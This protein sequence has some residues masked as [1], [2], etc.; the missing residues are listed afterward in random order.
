MALLLAV[1]AC[2]GYAHAENPVR[3]HLD[4]DGEWQ[5]KIDPLDAGEQQR[6]YLLQ[7]KFDQTI[8]V[9]GCWQAQGIGSPSGILRHDYSGN[10]WYRRVVRVPSDWG[11]RRITL[12]I[13][14]ALRVVTAFVNGQPAGRHDGMSAPFAFD[15]TAQVEPGADN[16]IALRVANPGAAPS[17]SP[18]RQP[19]TRPTGSLNA[20]GNWGG[21]FEPVELQAT[22]QVWLDRIRVRSE[23]E[24]KTIHFRV[25][26]RNVTPERFTGSLRV[27]VPGT[28][29]KGDVA[30]PPGQ[31]TET[32]LTL[33]MPGAQLWSPEHPSLYSAVISLFRGAE[34][35][36]RLEQRFG[37]SEVRTQGNV[38]LLNNKP[39]YLRGYGDDDVEILSGTPSSSRETYVK[40]LQLARAM[41]FNAV[42]FHSMTP[43]REFYEAADE[44]GILVMAELPVAYTQYLLPFK[45]FLRSELTEVLL[46]YDNHPS[47]L[48]LALGNEFNLTWLKDDAA[49]GEFLAT[50]ADFYKLAKSLDPDRLILS[51]DG[52]LMEPTDMVSKSGQVS[53]TH[54][55]VRHEFGG[56]YCSLPDVSLI[57]RFSGV[58]R[59]LWLE[60]KQNWIQENGLAAVYPT[61][62]KNSTILQYLGHKYEIEK[63]RARQDVTGYHYWL[64]VDF[65]GGTGEGDS[66]EEGWLNYFWEP[67]KP[68]Q[69]VRGLNSAVLMMIGA[70]VDDRTFWS[71]AGKQTG[72]LVSNYG[73]EDIEHGTLSWKLMDQDRAL[74]GSQVT[75]VGV[76]MGRV[77]HVADVHIGPIQAREAKKLSLVLELRSGSRTYSNDWDFWVFPRG[78]LMDRADRPVV[79]S[80]KWGGILRMY[81]FIKQ[82]S[83]LPPPDS[84]LLTSTLNATAKQ[85]LLAGGR[86]WLMAD[87]IQ[88]GRSGNATFFPAS[89]GAVGSRLLDHPAL[90]GFPN[91]GF[92]D[93]QFFNLLEGAWNYS[94]DEWPKDLV[95]I[96]GSIQTASSFLSKRKDLSKRGYIF[97]VAAGGGKLLVTTLS[98]RE[99]LDEAYPE[100]VA[101]FDRL[102][103][104]ASGPA[105]NPQTSV[106]PA[107][108]DSLSTRQEN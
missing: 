99:H 71:D 86:V 1:S 101:L 51:N 100:A 96:A 80:V 75:G 46:E 25:L 88:F 104:Y 10:A 33:A 47:F 107:L 45:D 8:R 94:L 31:T 77:E 48:S 14:G 11:G 36:D 79:S 68:P 2:C 34:E 69:Q 108:F 52:L 83:G 16:V 98:I 60:Q 105:F 37:I 7:Q 42:R 15:V 24:T 23:V 30:I 19:P 6:W 89:G 53:K 70:G 81:P 58:I 55:T 74:A 44:N 66:W 29:A 54:P 78:G 40:R 93:L 26:L 65:P 39:L 72:V 67:K 56:Y 61:Y 28:Q 103:R 92:F 87:R 12:R 82:L 97:E 27:A 76:R 41:G 85:F 43:V 64:M 38:L 5:F 106:S 4:L 63:A 90:R 9:P 59:P 21:L 91:Q 73:E 17:E 35:I 84:L 49:R 13:G 3:L 20:I 57:D 32:S 95:P 62:L 18:D 50:V 102:L 22:S